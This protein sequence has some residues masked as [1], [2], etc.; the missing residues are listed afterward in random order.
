MGV[1]V[2]KFLK[3]RVGLL[4]GN[5]VIEDDGLLVGKMLG[6]TVGILFLRVDLLVGT[7]L[8]ISVGF[9]EEIELGQ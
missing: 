4:D 1:R 2:G 5:M 9:G 8:G 3:M 7:T 6:E